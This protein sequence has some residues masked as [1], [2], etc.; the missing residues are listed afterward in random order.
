MGHGFPIDYR[1]MAIPIE[2]LDTLIGYQMAT[3]MP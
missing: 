2:N 3:Y 1:N